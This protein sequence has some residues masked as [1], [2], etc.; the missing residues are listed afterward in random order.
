MR[1]GRMA[2]TPKV[3]R[4][5]PTLGYIYRPR[6]DPSDPVPLPTDPHRA[7]RNSLDVWPKNRGKK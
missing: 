2:F 5:I 6:T 7:P 1:Q 3:D 4:T